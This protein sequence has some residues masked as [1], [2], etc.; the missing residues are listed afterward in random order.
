MIVTITKRL[1]DQLL[2]LQGDDFWERLADITEHP[3]EWLC[4]KADGK[5]T[6]VLYEVVKE[7][8]EYGNLVSTKY[9]GNRRVLH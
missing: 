6:N 1:R 7:S 2:K 5:T 3:P 8:E 9:P 4:S